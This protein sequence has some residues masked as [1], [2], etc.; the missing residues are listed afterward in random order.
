[1]DA[2][3]NTYQL[4]NTPLQSKYIDTDEYLAIHNIKQ[5]IGEM[6]N[7]LLHEMDDHPYVFMVKYLSSKV[8]DEELYKNNIEIPSP[9]PLGRPIVKYPQF[10]SNSSSLLSKY[11]TSEMWAKI[12]YRKTKY[13]GNINNI[14]ILIENSPFDPIGCILSDGD[15][16]VTFKE[17]LLPL[18]AEVHKVDISVQENK[19]FSNIYEKVTDDDN[20]Y[21]KL[22]SRL[23]SFSISFC[24]NLAGIPFNQYLQNDTREYIDKVFNKE[25]VSLVECGV[26]PEMETLNFLMNQFECEDIIKKIR[27]N[28]DLMIKCNM[29]QFWPYSRSIYANKERT[30]AILIN[31]IDHLYLNVMCKSPSVDIVK[32]INDAITIIKRLNMNLAFESSNCFGNITTMLNMFGAGMKMTA[33]LLIKNLH[34][35]SNLNINKMLSGMGFDVYKFKPDRDNETKLYLEKTFKLSYKS[36]DF[37]IKDFVYGVSGLSEL[38][39]YSFDNK[40]FTMME[41]NK[42]I[43]KDVY[44]KC[45]DEIKYRLAYNGNN[46]NDVILNKETVLFSEKNEY[47]SFFIFVKEFLLK[48]QEFDISKYEHIHKREESD[49]EEKEDELNFLVGDDNKNS[50]DY[51]AKVKDITIVV[52]RNIKGLSFPWKVSDLKVD[53][54]ALKGKMVHPEQIDEDENEDEKEKENNSENNSSEKAEEFTNDN[55]RAFHIIKEAVDALNNPND[56]ES[57][58]FKSKGQI[59]LTEINEEA[60]EK[61]INV[62]NAYKDEYKTHI[63]PSAKGVIIF[64]SLNANK[65]STV[66]TSLIGIVNNIDHLKFVYKVS[67]I[68]KSNI[69]N[70]THFKDAFAFILRFI[71]EITREIDFVYDINLGFI[72][73]SP[74][75]LGTAIVL[76]FTLSNLSY[77]TVSHLDMASKNIAK[78]YVICEQI[79]ST[80]VS[81]R[82]KRTIGLSEVELYAKMKKTI[83]DIISFDNSSGKKEQSNKK[84][85]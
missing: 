65:R 3:N 73:A 43:L 70:E 76:T 47:D 84:K 56:V 69:I 36:M 62:F 66:I 13:G 67:P 42:G 38:D 85:K 22:N 21:A 48:S 44:E 16:I 15:A 59:E 55:Q 8:P 72:T 28:D 64:P 46:I 33:E 50:Y 10:P 5:T 68:I 14:T 32:S 71:N 41:L 17:L 7:N 60:N 51:N 61:S 45:F 9:L 29:K 39:K 40:K 6:V 74:S 35:N 24:R 81:V 77:Y 83:R 58:L 4:N 54:V 23:I 49:D 78:G 82:N 2:N 34:K 37:F 31:F 19:K 79:S 52:R 80:S 20:I 27:F 25:I 53:K 1:M 75:Y 26:L 57:S 18:I 11:L 30:I 12:K 63:D